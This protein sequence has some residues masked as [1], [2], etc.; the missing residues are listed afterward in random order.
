MNFQS[1]RRFIIG[2][3][4]IA[5]LALSGCASGSNANA[6][7]VIN[8]NQATNGARAHVRP[9]RLVLHIVIPRKQKNHQRGRKPQYV[10]P[11]TKSITVTL[12]GPTAV[13][14]TAP[15]TPT[16]QGCTSSLASTSCTLSIPGL[17][18]GNYTG[19]MSTW[20]TTNGTG[21]EL[22]A[23]QNVSFKITTGQANPIGITLGGIPTAVLIVPDPAS[24]L[25]GS[26]SAGFTLSKCGSDTLS[27]Y[28]VDADKNI[29]LGA[30]APTPS[31]QSD[32]PSTLAVSTPTPASPNRFTIVRPSPPPNPGS[33]VHL[34]A[35]I[36]PDADSGAS[37][38][39]T[40]AIPMT[41][42]H[43]ICGVVTEFSTGITSNSHPYG[44]TSGPD[45]NLWFTE[46]N[47]SQFAKI[48]TGG[49]VTE[50]A[51]VF[52]P[53][54]II[55]GPDGNLWLGSFNKIVSISTSGTIAAQYSSGI[56]GTNLTGIAS[57]PD[58]N[59][60]FTEEGGGSGNTVAKIT[61]SGTVTEYSTGITS[62]ANPEDI[63]T[64]PDGNLWFTEQNTYKIA[65]ITTGGV[66][67]EYSSGIS[68]SATP[69]HITQ[70]PD[71]A[72]WFTEVFTN[73]IG[74]ITTGGTVTEYS[75]ASFSGP[76]GITA[77]PDGNLWFAE[78]ADRIGKITTGG[79]VTEY[80]A[81]ITA[82]SGPYGVTFG[83][84]GNLWFT[85]KKGN[86]I[87]RMQ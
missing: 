71:G 86:R 49:T 61:T 19:S 51:G 60:W 53:Y 31:L 25:T 84:D 70:G 87:A 79:I 1:R 38:V 45:G 65:K 81:G 42:N 67:T 18:P 40:P 21:H 50:Y 44:I 29:I 58:G 43:D 62:G 32:T 69:E 3:A 80:S 46:C 4:L 30:G 34:T 20:D 24:S 17:A 39:S 57:G 68:A 16:S 52:L 14:T 82:G 11:A 76:Q 12:T 56:S 59:L 72:L 26:M 63:T 55:V 10:S 47:V 9:G 22:S 77:G 5:A 75:L 73:K 6:I 33:M 83:P 2:P 8:G 35:T 66:V 41:F 28:G 15:L 64:G 7:P 54:D 78:T 27:I 13:A 36:T 85:E 37:P 74:R 23:N 48:T